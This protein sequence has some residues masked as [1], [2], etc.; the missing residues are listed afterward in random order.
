M[1]DKKQ[2]DE[3]VKEHF[4]EFSGHLEL[5]SLKDLQQFIWEYADGRWNEGYDY[6]IDIASASLKGD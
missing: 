5:K 2:L 3:K 1:L 6:A 4:V